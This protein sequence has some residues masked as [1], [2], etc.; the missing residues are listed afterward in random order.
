M[1]LHR[2]PEISTES[3]GASN[4]PRTARGRLTRPPC[5]PQLLSRESESS[6]IS[7]GHSLDREGNRYT[8][9]PTGDA[10]RIE[11]GEVEESRN[12]TPKITYP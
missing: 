7:S 9:A 2:S 11:S 1:I 4:R 10:S 8:V 12:A 6:P 3:L 5:P